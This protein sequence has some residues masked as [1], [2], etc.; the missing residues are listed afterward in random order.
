MFRKE[1]VLLSAD[2]VPTKDPKS[3]YEGQFCGELDREGSCRTTSEPHSNHIRTA[4]ESMQHPKQWRKLGEKRFRPFRGQKRLISI[5]HINFFCR[6]SPP[7]CPRDKPGLSQRQT[8]LPLCNIRRKSQFVPGT[9]WVCPWDNWGMSQG[10]TGVVPSATG[11]KRLC[12]CAFFLPEYGCFRSCSMQ[13]SR[14][15]YINIGGCNF[16]DLFLRA[17]F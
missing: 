16:P 2:F 15:Y 11:P 9:T 3:P 12:L 10:Q 14:S 7:V 17:I 8:G 4:F 5:W 1:P 6:H 13:L